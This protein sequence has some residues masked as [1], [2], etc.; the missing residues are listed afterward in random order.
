MPK[1]VCVCVCVRACER[2]R[3]CA[4]VSACV[5]ACVCVMTHVRACNTCIHGHI[6]IV[7]PRHM[8]NSYVKFFFFF[9]VAV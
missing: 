8:A 6:I 3:A 9:R 1:C 7:G 4:C 5:R 2:V